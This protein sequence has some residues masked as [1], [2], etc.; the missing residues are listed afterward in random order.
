MT[1]ELSVA[2][3]ACPS[4][5][6]LLTRLREQLAPLEPIVCC[7]DDESRDVWRQYHR[8]LTE[9]EIG[10]H[11]LV[12]QDDALLEPCFA[13]AAQAALEHRPK[14]VVCF[15]VPALPAYYGRQMIQAR[16]SGASFCEL[17]VRG[18]FTPLVCTAWPAELAAEFAAW[19]GHAKRRRDR[20]DDA[21]AAEWMTATRRTALAS[22]PCLADHDET[23]PSALANGGRYSRRAAILPD[24]PA[25]ELS[26]G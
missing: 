9:G 14:R 6:R 3:Q 18:M 20:A 8:C 13:A 7:D 17:A 5:A 21:R 4:R 11:R 24:T 19:P 25:G 1:V 10:T 2:I 15:Y 26:I 12:V 23:V 22:V 16:E